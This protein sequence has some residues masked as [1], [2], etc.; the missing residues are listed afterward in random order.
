M[1]HS[2]ASPA[3]ELTRLRARSGRWARHGRN[4]RCVQASRR[5]RC[6]RATSPR[7]CSSR[8]IMPQGSSLERHRLIG[9]RTRPH[10][11]QIRPLGPP[12]PQHSLRVSW[13]RHPSPPRYITWVLLLKEHRAVGKLM[14]AAA[15]LLSMVVPRGGGWRRAGPTPTPMRHLGTA[16]RCTP[17]EIKVMGMVVERPSRPPSSRRR[18]QGQRD[19]VTHELKRDRTKEVG[20]HLGG[21]RTQHV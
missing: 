4:D 12:R 6:R 20:R 14:G 10:A 15:T 16:P 3:V 1:N 8:R 21:R 9:R 7:C 18:S 13:P 2:S 11:R 5:A 19:R 17:G